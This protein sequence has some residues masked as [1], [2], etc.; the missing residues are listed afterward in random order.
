MVKTS[1]ILKATVIAMLVAL[2]FASFPTAGVAAKETNPGLESRWSQLVTSYNRQSSN[3]SS[4]HRWVDHWLQTSKK[5]SATRKAE[6]QKHL[7]ICNSA[8]VGAGIVV[9]KHAGFDA[10]GNLVDRAAAIKSIN[11]LTY[12]LKL[13]AGSV[14]NL[15]G[16]INVRS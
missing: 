2:V 5:L 9:A 8:I 4:A 6:V 10:K 1:L 12:Y 15:K 7:D 16:H 14:K 3:H 11:D 13:H